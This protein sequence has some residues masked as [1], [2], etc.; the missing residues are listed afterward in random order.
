M[1]EGG[2]T[3]GLLWS[4]LSKHLERDVILIFVALFASIFGSL[5]R[6][7]A[8]MLGINTKDIE[9]FTRFERIVI[10]LLGLFVERLTAGLWVLAVFN[11]FSTFR[12]KI[13]VLHLTFVLDKSQKKGL[14]S[15]ADI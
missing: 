13:Y 3:R 6:S 14:S 7:R 12:R 5:A 1:M 2:L 9:L 11:K 4:S 15:K 10:L 8:G